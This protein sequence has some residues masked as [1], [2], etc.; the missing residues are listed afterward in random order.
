MASAAPVGTEQPLHAQK[1][2]PGFPGRQI[3]DKGL[4]PGEAFVFNSGMLKTPTPAQHEL[5][6]VTLEELVPKD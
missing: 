6:M 1:N 5:E 4:A 3:A 2:G